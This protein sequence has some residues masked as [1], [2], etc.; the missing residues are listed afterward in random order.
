KTKEGRELIRYRTDTPVDGNNAFKPA[1]RPIRDPKVDSSA[2]QAYVEGLAF[3]KKSKEREARMAYEEALKRDAGFAPAHTA[4]GLSYYRSAEYEKA[5]SHLT[6]AL[7][8]NGDAADAHYYLALVRR[9]QGEHREAADH[10]IWLVGAGYRESVAR[11]VLGEMALADGQVAAA[12]EN[13]S[14]AVLL[15]PR[16]LKARTVLALAERLSGKLD[17]SHARIDAVVLEMPIDYLALH[18]QYET[19]KALGHDAKAKDAWT[20]LWRLLAREPASILELAFDSTNAGRR[21]EALTILEEAIKRADQ[22]T[23]VYPML[24][25]T[26]GYLYEQDGDRERARAHYVLGSKGD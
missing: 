11:Y 8:R 18:E 9:A 4:L 21:G 7:T 12:L 15:D 22:T 2:E 26:L 25:Y 19:C 1:M 16:D 24:H 23:K 10:L 3:D 17:A 6:Q 20:Q 14:Q 13:L 5:A